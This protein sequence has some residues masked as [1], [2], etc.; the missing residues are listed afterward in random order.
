[1]KILFLLILMVINN[2]SYANDLIF[3]HGFE[4][5]VAVTGETTGLSSTGLNLTL[6][7]N[8][9]NTETIGIISNGG[10]VFATDLAVGENWNVIISTLP[11]SPQQSCKLNNASGTITQGGVENLQVNCVSTEWNWDE[12][13]WD[14]GGWN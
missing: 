13:N 5:T 4:N 2:T 7:I 6:Y 1:M 12:M 9:N 3:K 10:F 8:G 11:N 14:E